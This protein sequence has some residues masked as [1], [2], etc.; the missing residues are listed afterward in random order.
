MPKS[1]VLLVCMQVHQARDALSNGTL[2]SLSLPA[3]DYSAK[4]GRLYLVRTLP[5]K[6]T[7][8]INVYDSLK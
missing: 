6:M 3:C 7:K 8:V 1:I 5:L 4:V 2:H